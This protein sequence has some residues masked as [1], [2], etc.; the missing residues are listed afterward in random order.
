MSYKH[1]LAIRIG[2]EKTIPTAHNGSSAS[3]NRYSLC[4]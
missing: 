1:I 3:S 2:Y 4:L